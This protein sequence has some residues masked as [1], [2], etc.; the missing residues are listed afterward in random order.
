M[1]CRHDTDNDLVEDV[2]MLIHNME[3]RL[4]V[5]G[6]IQQQLQDIRASINA[7][8]DA[9]NQFRH[10]IVVL[11]N[12]VIRIYRATRQLGVQL[13]FGI[14]YLLHPLSVAIGE[15]LLKVGWMVEQQRTPPVVQVFHTVLHTLL[16]NCFGLRWI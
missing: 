3:Q 2:G 11:G 4:D 16:F 7:L 5:I 12:H 8:D 10:P 1:L 6:D 14:D 9:V 15:I 13:R